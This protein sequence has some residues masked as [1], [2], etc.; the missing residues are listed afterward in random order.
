MIL[1]DFIYEWDGKS[2]N[3]EPP[4]TWWPGAY[5]VRIVTLGDEQTKIQY[6]FPTAV[7]LK[8]IKTQGV[9]NTSLKNYIHNFAQKI[10][11]DYDLDTTKTLWVELGDKIRIAHLSP[12]GKLSDKALL[13]FSWRRIRPNELKIIVPYIQ[14]L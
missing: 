1:H 9:M 10:S 11:R 8:G 5:R 4:V 12:G 7:I 13:S 2:Q 3:G 6:L 14:D